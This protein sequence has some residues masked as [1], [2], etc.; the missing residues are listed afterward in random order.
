MK[1]KGAC[2]SFLPLME[3]G[4][5]CFFACSVEIQ[6]GRRQPHSKTLARHEKLLECASPLALFTLSPI[7]LEEVPSF[8]PFV[9]CKPK[10]GRGLPH[11]KTL[12]RFLCFA[13]FSHLLPGR[14]PRFTFPGGRSLGCLGTTTGYHLA[15]LRDATSFAPC[16]ETTPGAKN[17]KEED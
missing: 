15:S 17:R 12:A 2:L 3:G 14:K 11:S 5:V 6:S 7:R 16:Q 4:L 9:A 1:A 8:S 13:I 10:S